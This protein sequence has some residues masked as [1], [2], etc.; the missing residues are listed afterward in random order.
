MDN[1]HIRTAM[2]SRILGKHAAE[3]IFEHNPGEVE[4]ES[5]SEMATNV[6]NW[7]N[8]LGT[9]SLGIGARGGS[10]GVWY[11]DLLCTPQSGFR[12]LLLR[13]DDAVSSYVHAKRPKK[14]LSF[15]SDGLTCIFFYKET[16]PETEIHFANNQ[17]LFNFERFIRDGST[18]TPSGGKLRDID[19][20]AVDE[21]EVG[22]GEASGYDFIQVAAWDVLYDEDLLKRCVAALAQD[23]VLMIISSNNSGKV[24]RDDTMLHPYYKMHEILKNSSGTTYHNSDSYGFT[25]FIKTT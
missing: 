5:L 25:V 6:R 8:G 10:E 20:S 17:C 7:R 11:I 22:V 15:T 16:H 4:I 23:G 2:A 3:N 21:D 9:L 14:I 19:Y 1:K 24:Y 13:Y 18:P 12:E